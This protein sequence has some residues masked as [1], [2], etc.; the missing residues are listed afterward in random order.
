MW[1][2]IIYIEYILWRM[3][4]TKSVF[5]VAHMLKFYLQRCVNEPLDVQACLFM[6][7]NRGCTQYLVVSCRYW[8]VSLISTKVSG[9]SQI[10][11]FPL[12]H[13]I[14]LYKRSQTLN[15][16]IGCFFSHKFNFIIL[17][18]LN[19]IFI[20]TRPVQEISARSMDK[21]M[22]IDYQLYIIITTELIFH[23]LLLLPLFPYKTAGLHSIRLNRDTEY[24][25][26]WHVSIGKTIPDRKVSSCG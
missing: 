18:K 24:T 23:T 8:V 4:T 17:F 16:W 25:M 13:L 15:N 1:I 2:K 21:V 6:F 19:V 20:E 12:S 11:L 9:Y 10:I 14:P 5:D 3:L 26:R 7:W 22:F